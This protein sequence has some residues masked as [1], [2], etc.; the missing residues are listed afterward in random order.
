MCLKHLNTTVLLFQ[1]SSN[2]EIE[3][4][5]IFDFA[6]KIVIKKRRERLEKVLNNVNTHQFSTAL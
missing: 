4:L 1:P 3:L 5:E 6:K 2:I